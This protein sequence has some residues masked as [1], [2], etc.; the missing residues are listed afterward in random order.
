MIS[1][2]NKNTDTCLTCESAGLNFCE[3]CENSS[4][5][6]CLPG[7]VPFFTKR[8]LEI[9]DTNRYSHTNSTITERTCKRCLRETETDIH[10]HPDFYID[11]V[12][13]RCLERC[14][15]GRT[16]FPE[17]L[18]ELEPNRLNSCDD[19]NLFP[20]DGCS[21]TCE[22][23]KSSGYFCE[24]EGFELSKKIDIYGKNNVWAKSV[25]QVNKNADVLVKIID[26]PSMT[27]G[28]YFLGDYHFTNG[29]ENS[30]QVN[31]PSRANYKIPRTIKISDTGPNLVELA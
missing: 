1:L 20:G 15:D 30:I 11:T 17:A 8:T 26:L 2:I 19:G 16:Y 4:C 18:P 3:K 28:I 12:T 5:L 10:K 31:I 22:I 23:E 7:Y 24:F 29:I 25:C 13:G 6:K 27:I 21:E 14:G 9:Y